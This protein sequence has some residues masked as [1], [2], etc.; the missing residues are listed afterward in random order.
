M[1]HSYPPSR[2]TGC[3]VCGAFPLSAFRF[4]L[5]TFRFLL[6]VFRFPFSVF[7][8]PFSVFCFY[9]ISVL[10]MIACVRRGMLRGRWAMPC[11]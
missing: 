2:K 4:P 7:R 3:E 10:G 1:Y 11:G 6:S 8:F 5:S 9:S